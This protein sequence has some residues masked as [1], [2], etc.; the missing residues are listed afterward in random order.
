MEVENCWLGYLPDLNQTVPYVRSQL[1]YWIKWLVTTYNVDRLRIDTCLEAP[2]DFWSEFSVSAG[3]YTVCEVYDGSIILNAGYQGVVDGT[4][5]Y[6]MFYLMRDL[7][8]SSHS[9]YK[10]RS[11]MA[12]SASMF[13]NM[14]YEAG[15]VDNHD[16][17]RFLYNFPKVN[18]LK[19]ALVWSLTWLGIPIVYYGSEQGFNGDPDPQ[20]REPLWPYLKSTNSDHYKFSTTAI[21]YRKSNQIWKYERVERYAADSFYCYSHGQFL[22]A[23]S[24]TDN[25]IFYQVPYN[26]YKVGDIV[27][28][29]FYSGD[30]VTV[31]SS[32]VPIYLDGGEVKLY[33]LKSSLSTI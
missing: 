27:C 24:N 4:L 31:T 15:F 12:Q 33:Q 11:F 19:N 16:N 6:P 1:L 7:F 25:N 2:K 18:R 29:V 21:T 3:V 5:N 32:G 20:C 13:K 23:F 9:M 30:C 10:A 14:G 26:P 22:M 8:Q 17:P 28:N